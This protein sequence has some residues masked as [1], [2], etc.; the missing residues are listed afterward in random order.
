MHG[1]SYLRLLTTIMLCCVLYGCGPGS[2]QEPQPPQTSAQASSD[3]MEKW[4]R[5]C[6]LC[7]I[8]GTGGAPRVGDVEDWTSRLEQGDE[9]LLTHTVEGY[10]NMPP[11]GYCM[12]CERADFITLIDFM[13]RGSRP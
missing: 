13:S 6:S 10:N 8:D 7:H 4:S 1:T 3:P 11:L 9:V 2:V 12:D 5:S